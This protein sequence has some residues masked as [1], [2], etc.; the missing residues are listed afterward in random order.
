MSRAFV[1]QSIVFSVSFS[2]VAA[3]AGSGGSASGPLPQTDALAVGAAQR[4]VSSSALKPSKAT[5]KS[6]YS[7]RGPPDGTY[8]S[9]LTAVNG[10]FYGTT[11]AGGAYGSPST[12]NGYGTVF[13]L[14]TSGAERVLHSF[15]SGTDGSIPLTTSGLSDVNGALY[16]TTEIGGVGGF[17][18][19]FEVSTSGA[20]RAIYSFNGALDGSTPEQGLTAVNGSL[21]GTTEGGGQYGFGTVF[22]V[23]MS[24]AERVIYSFQGGTA[25]G[26]Y[27]V[28]SLTAVNGALYGI[29]TA[30]GASGGFGTVFKV[31]TSGAERVI[32]N[33]KGAPDGALP[34][35]GL[36]AVNGALYGT[37]STGGTKTNS[38]SNLSTGCGTVFEVSTSGAE[39]VL[40]SFKGGT[41]GEYPV[42]GLIDVKG[43]LYGTTE[44]GGTSG[45][46]GFGT[47]FEVSTSGA[48]RVLYSF[49]GPPDGEYPEAGLIDVKGALY[50]TT[51]LGGVYGTSGHGT[52][53][54]VSL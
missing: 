18:T 45:I 38:C 7:F 15:G 20:E 6:L 23:S 28:T 51:A 39:R 43:A 10:A 8:P 44:V 32:Y 29:T 13:E 47:V 49:K 34:Y 46:V 4:S 54:E 42:A 22:K 12:Y 53:F 1:L 31:S 16:G 41:D 24:G 33:F 30:G 35:A 19:V 17:G 27:P 3:C 40:Y 48:E 50:G 37:T 36:T 11:S 2:L 9:G 25:D 21:Y 5:Y 14:S 52:V 26:S